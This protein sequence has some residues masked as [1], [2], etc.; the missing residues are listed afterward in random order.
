MDYTNL[1]PKLEKVLSSISQEE[2]SD[3][4]RS[5]AMSNDDMAMALVERFWRPDADE[6]KDIVDACFMHPSIIRTRYGEA[7]DWEAV[8][9]DVK[10]LMA[11]IRKDKKGEDLIGAA[12]T[13]LY[14]L[15]CTCEEYDKDH[16]TKEFYGERWM[17]RWCPLTDCNR[18]SEKNRHFIQ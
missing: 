6:Y 16:P 2:L 13:A 9:K 11:K 14:L 15:V 17:N 18:K 12:Q 5:Y 1:F 4:A 8:T 7:L 10:V 3:F